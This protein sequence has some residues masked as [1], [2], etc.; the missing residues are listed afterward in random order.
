MDEAAAPRDESTQVVLVAGAT[1]YVG[2]R[3]IP[4]LL[5]SGRRVRALARTPAKLASR[6]FRD[7]AGLEVVQGDV[8]DP[9]SLERA[10]VG[11]DAAY[12]LVHSMGGGHP[13]KSGGFA[14]ADIT[15]A[16]NF[17]AACA[18]A[19]VQR[20][21]YLSGLGRDTDDLSMHLRSRHDTGEA[22]AE[23]GVPVTE[24]RAA[25]IVG[26]GSA[27]FDMIH[28]LARRLP[29]M[30]T[31]RWVDSQCEPIAIRDVTWYLV[32]VLDEPRTIGEVLEIGSGDVHRYVDLIRICAEELG[33]PFRNVTV[34][35]ISPRLSSYWLHLVTSVDMDVA[36]PLVE[37]LRNDVVCDDLRI[38]EWMPRELSSYRLSVRRA[39]DKIAAAD[40]RE[41]RWA[42][43]QRQGIRPPSS[44]GR[45]PGPRLRTRVRF[46]PQRE[47]FR[48]Y[49]TF[50][51]SLTP[52]ELYRRVV[53]IGGSNGYGR[54]VDPLWRLRGL[55]DRVTGGPGLRRGRPPGDQLHVGDA[56]DF[57]RVERLVPERQLRLVAEMRVPGAA[58]LDFRIEPRPG[59]SRLHQ[60]ATL[61]NDSIWSGLYWGVI[62][63]VHDPV[64]TQLGRH[65]IAEDHVTTG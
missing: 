11:V 25:V 2:G 57:W 42:D 44:V 35:L 15:A 51:T 65:I 34:P 12:Y 3:L 46:W 14:T 4:E 17:G 60:L 50:D 63:P 47:E 16:R 5:E 53:E 40:L 30:L 19:G 13:N 54:H 37:G 64:F 1:G 59:G 55:F 49:R 33:L 32:G 38:R 41:S 6:A 9:A 27:S 62:A 20:I 10:L 58:R 48:D 28:D 56:L 43:A 22:L 39:L 52:A 18:A 61:E 21:I 29:A 45:E 7:D 23:A 26:S 24:L 8:F 31:P 36:R